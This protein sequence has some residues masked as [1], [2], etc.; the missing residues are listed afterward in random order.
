MSK[1]LSDILFGLAPSPA[2]P[3]AKFWKDLIDHSMINAQT[4]ESG[5][6]MLFPMKTMVTVVSQQ[7]NQELYFKV[8]IDLNTSPYTKLT[9]SFTVPRSN[10]ETIDGMAKLDKN[11][12][13]L[14]AL[15]HQAVQINI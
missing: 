6:K 5:V 13:Q 8:H 9:Q 12:A 1:T 4:M 2:P 3:K 15:F 7:A 11:I 10:V 14:A